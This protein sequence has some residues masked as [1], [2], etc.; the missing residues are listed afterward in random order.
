MPSSLVKDKMFPLALMWVLAL[1]VMTMGVL[2]SSLKVKVRAKRISP[3]CLNPG[4]AYAPIPKVALGL[5]K[6]S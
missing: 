6:L 1:G 5:A 4:W 3:P 2:N